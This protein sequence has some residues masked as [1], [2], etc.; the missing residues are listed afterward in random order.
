MYN[1]EKLL[2][3][4]DISRKNKE[5]EEQEKIDKE[6]EKEMVLFKKVEEA[7]IIFCKKGHLL[8]RLNISELQDIAH[9]LCS[10]EKKGK[11]DDYSSHSGSKKNLN[12]RM[13]EV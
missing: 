11:R 2:L 10:M 4:W 7:Y 13:A 8:D 5:Q 1:S 6:K 9:F 12:E 3:V